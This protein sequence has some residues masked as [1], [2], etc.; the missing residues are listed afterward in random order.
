M[1]E[2]NATWVLYKLPTKVTGSISFFS[3]NF[4]VISMPVPRVFF[5][6]LKTNVFLQQVTFSRLNRFENNLTKYENNL[7]LSKQFV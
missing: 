7:S 3:C 4:C 1:F 6:F 2:H 5:V